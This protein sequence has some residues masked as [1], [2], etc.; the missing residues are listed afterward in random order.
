MYQKI[1]NYENLDQLSDIF[2]KLYIKY[3]CTNDS[4]KLKI[5]KEQLIRIIYE[6]S[7]IMESLKSKKKI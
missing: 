6:Y 4:K 2:Y 1:N 7:E 3:A 5:I